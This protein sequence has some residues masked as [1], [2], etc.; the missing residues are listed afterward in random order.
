MGLIHSWIGILRFLTVGILLVVCALWTTSE[1]EH[2]SDCRGENSFCV[3]Q[4]CDC[5]HDSNGYQ[6]QHD[7]LYSPKYHVYRGQGNGFSVMCLVV[8]VLYAIAITYWSVSYERQR[9]TIP[10]Q[11]RRT[12]S[13]YR[14]HS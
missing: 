2:H 9:R 8:L 4:Y 11:F 5:G 14:R 10:R 6:C 3:A 12:S 1:C 13:I 7:W